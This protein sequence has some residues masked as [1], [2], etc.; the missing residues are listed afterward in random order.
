MGSAASECLLRARHCWAAAAALRSISGVHRAC[1]MA[2]AV[3]GVRGQGAFQSGRRGP[4]DQGARWC[5]GGNAGRVTRELGLEG[6]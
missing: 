2:A 5:A 1:V 3:V 6:L 4:S